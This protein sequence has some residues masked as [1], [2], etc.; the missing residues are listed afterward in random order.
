MY[1]LALS[2]AAVMSTL[3][4]YNRYLK[5]DPRLQVFSVIQ[6]LVILAFCLAVLIKAQTFGSSPYCNHL[7][8][9]RI[10]A[11]EDRWLIPALCVSA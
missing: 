9:V 11:A 8:Q 10:E 2:W 4:M 3:P 7:A 5:I 1:L 6:T